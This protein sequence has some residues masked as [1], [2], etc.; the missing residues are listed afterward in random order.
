MMSFPMILIPKVDDSGIDASTLG[1]QQFDVVQATG[2]E[3]SV[4]VEV[5]QNPS[6]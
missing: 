5:A 4:F 3:M 2:M 6:S 1:S